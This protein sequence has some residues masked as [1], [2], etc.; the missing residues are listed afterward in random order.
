MDRLYDM[1]RYGNVD[2]NNDGVINEKD[3]GYQT[4]TLYSPTGIGAANLKKDNSWVQNAYDKNGMLKKGDWAGD[5]GDTNNAMDD[6]LKSDKFNNGRVPDVS[7]VENVTKSGD[8]EIIIMNDTQ[9]T[10]VK[11]IVEE[12]VL[13]NTFFSEL[14][15]KAIQ[16]S[17]RYYVYKITNM[18][19]DYQS[20]QELFIV[21]RSILLQHANF[22]INQQK[23]FDEVRKLNKMVVDYCVKEVSSNVQQYDTY[24]KD[25]EKLPVPLDRPSFDPATG[26]TTY[27]LSNFVGI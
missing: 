8:G 4:D 14:N 11:G 20:T 16:D 22:K 17:I 7:M 24:V 10:A 21:M 9:Q 27:D 3:D 25:L 2:T 18:V 26:N 15:R 23:L 19:I 1:D 5:V 13:S 6:L 12:T